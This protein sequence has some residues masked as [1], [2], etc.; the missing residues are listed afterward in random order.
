[1][2]W[3]SVLLGASVLITSAICQDD[4]E[5]FNYTDELGRSFNAYTIPDAGITF[6]I[7]TSEISTQPFDIILQVTGEVATSGWVGLSWG[8]SMTYSPLAL[9]WINGE[10]V[11][12]SSRMAFGYFVPPLFEE[13]TYTVLPG[14]SVNETHYTVTALCK[15]C[16]SW[17]PFDDTPTLLNGDGENYLAFAYSSVPVDDPTNIDTTFGIH[18]RVGHWIHNLD[19]AKS[20]DFE[21]WAAEAGEAPAPPEESAPPEETATP[22]A[23]TEAP[24]AGDGESTPAPDTTTGGGDDTPTTLLTTTSTPPEEPTAT[25][26]EGGEEPEPTAAKPSALPLPTACPGVAAPAFPL[27]TA[28]GWNVVKISGGVR[29][30]R[31]VVV[32]DLGNL[33]VLEAGKGLSVHTLD[34][35]DGCISTSKM[36]IENPALNHGLHISPDARKVYVSS[37]TTAWEWSYDSAAQAVADQRVVVKN[38]YTGGHPSRSLVVP[39]ATPNLLVIQLGSNSNFDMESLD[40]AT[41]RANVKVF[42]VAEAPEGGWDWITEGWP[43]GYGLRNDIALIV[44]GNN[45]VW[46]AEN[47]ADQLTRSADGSTVDVHID[48]PAEELNYLGDPSKPNTDWYGYPVC[49]TVGNTA[50]FTDTTFSVGDQ[51][52]L[53][54]NTTFTDATCESESVGPRLSIQAHSAPIDGT[55]DADFSNLYITLHG[56]WNRAPATGYKVIQIAYTRLEDGSYDPVAPRDAGRD[57]YVDVLWNENVDGCTGN[58]CLRPTGITWDLAGTRMFVASDNAASGE[59]FILYKS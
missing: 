43:L 9:V 49:F 59:L 19:H 8:G 39:P 27:G 57:G 20:P 58:T 44:D 32:D 53:A 13:S 24:G 21:T 23:E 5:T 33:L 54:P 1:M 6:G 41:A 55:F 34:A 29:S 4:V 11:T 48:N 31:A 16:S 15:G 37:M 3:S 17:K 47:S 42:D 12:V 14:T 45:M 36:L 2:R 30:P 25:A 28:D 10:E 26:P 35:D 52:L 22:P 40:I 18:E 46:S 51:F 7:A 50:P 38:M 56:S